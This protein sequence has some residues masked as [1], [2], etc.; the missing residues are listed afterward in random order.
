[1]ATGAL[2]SMHRSDDLLQF[3]FPDER[4]RGDRTDG[5]DQLRTQQLNL[6]IEMRRTIRDLGCARHAIAAR[7]GIAA[8]KASNHCAHVDV[9]AKLRFVD[10]EAL[11]PAEQPLARGV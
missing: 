2:G 1:L 8:G 4:L 5:D 9:T 3:R 6:T 11:E 7:F 10:A